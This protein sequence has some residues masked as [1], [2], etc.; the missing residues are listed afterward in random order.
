MMLNFLLPVFSDLSSDNVQKVIEE[1]ILLS[2]AEI[3]NATKI[4][5]D[6][7]LFFRKGN[8]LNFHRRSI[9]RI[10]LRNSDTINITSFEVGLDFAISLLKAVSSKSLLCISYPASSAA[11]AA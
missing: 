3:F 6:L 10:T 8:R 11:F 5:S 9:F 2:L 1:K 7:I 4:N